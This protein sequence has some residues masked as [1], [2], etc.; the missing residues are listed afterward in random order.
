MVFCYYLDNFA[1]GDLCPVGCLSVIPFISAI[2]VISTG[3]AKY[4]G[5]IGYFDGVKLLS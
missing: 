4:R 2:N 3:N 5:A 1:R